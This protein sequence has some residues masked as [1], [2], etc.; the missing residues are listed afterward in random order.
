MIAAD[1]VAVL[2]LAA[3]TSTRFGPRDKLAEPLEGL[4]LG[5]HAART[6]SQLPF[7]ARVAVTRRGGPDFS[8]YG[9][10]PV[11]NPDPGA[12]QSGSIR[13]GLA[14]A[15][16]H[17]PKAVL[18]ALADMPFVSL[19]HFEALLARFDQGHPVIGSTDGNQPGPPV[20]FGAALFD[21]LGDLSGDVGA[22][23]L[24]RSAAL[25][26]AFPSELADIDSPADLLAS[27]RHMNA[28]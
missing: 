28:P 16:A 12:G 27:M 20:L 18:I 22:R 24:L 10:T 23:T 21:T 5:L 4:P 1:A 14:E 19:A 9:F 17:G 26:T 7:A 6:L 11:D 3:G 2:L 15:R 25:V 13:L 8:D